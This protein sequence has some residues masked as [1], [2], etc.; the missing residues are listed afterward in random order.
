MQ[1][2]ATELR[3]GMVLEKDNDLILIT[4]YSH[5]T[6]GNWRAIIQVKTKSLTSGQTG[7]F[8][9]AAGDMFETAFLDKKKAQYLY[10]EANGDF[11]FMDQETYDQFMILAALGADKMPFVRE[12]DIIEVTFHGSNPI[13]IALPTAVTLEVVEAEMA[14]KGNTATNVKKDAVLE[15]GQP[16]RVPLHIKAGERV[17]VNTDT[18]EF[19]SRAK[20]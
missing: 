14:V 1:V 15:T 8:R 17:V 9:P 7:S 16:I 4:D 19:M 10:K 20:D 12:S 18:G 5:A 3:K 2:K 11:V 6:P 13:G